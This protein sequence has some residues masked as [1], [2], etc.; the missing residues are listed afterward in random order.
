VLAA[1]GAAGFGV[2]VT[3]DY[4]TPFAGFDAIFVAEDFPT[5]GF[6]NNA[7]LTNYANGGG[8]VYL[9]G[10]A[11]PSASAEAAG[12]SLFLNHYGLAFESSGYNGLASVP[13]TSTHPI[14]AGI[15]ALE[16]GSGQSI[17]DLGSNPNA[18]IVQFASNQGV[19]AVVDVPEP[20]TLTL[21]GIGALLLAY[22]FR[23]RQ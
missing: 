9:A 1:L 19:Y 23:R 20:A 7:S 18:H 6:L 22:R 21:I 16:S 11:G 12:W 13:V 17:I 8:G 14:F 4:T 2:T 15:T 10:G 3:A 5:V